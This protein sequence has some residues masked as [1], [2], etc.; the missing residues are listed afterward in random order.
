VVVFSGVVVVFSG[1][2][3]VFSGVVVVCV[4]VV[5]LPL[6]LQPTTPMLKTQSA[7]KVNRNATNFFTGNFLSKGTGLGENPNQLLLISQTSNV[8]GELLTLL[9]GRGGS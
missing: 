9:L 3:V 2:V 8:N 1:V 6:S 4:V 7:P 5:F